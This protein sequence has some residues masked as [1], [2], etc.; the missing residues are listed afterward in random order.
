MSTECIILVLLYL[1]KEVANSSMMVRLL[2][3]ASLVVAVMSPVAEMVVVVVS[4]VAKGT[5]G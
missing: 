4:P 2:V 3:I 5:L 1:S